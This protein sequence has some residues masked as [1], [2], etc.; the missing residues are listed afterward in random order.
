MIRILATLATLLALAAG[1]QTVAPVA[2]DPGLPEGASTQFINVG[3]LDRSYLL[4]VPADLPAAAPLVVVL[5]GFGG[6]PEV[7]E[8]RLGWNQ[9]A[10]SAKFI[11]AYP[12]GIG[13]SWNAGPACCGTASNRQIDD[14]GFITRVVSD[15]G[16]RVPIAQDRVYA[17][18]MSNGGMMA[19]TLACNSDV[20]AA[21]GAVSATQIGQCNPPRPTSLIQ[22]HGTNDPLVPYSGG[23][24]LGFGGGMPVPDVDAFWRRIDGCGAPMVNT[25]GELT[26]S[27]AVCEGGRGVELATVAGGN[28]SWPP[29]ATSM[30]WEFFV[31]H[32]R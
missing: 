13:V 11:V 28:H 31:A 17:V 21:I 12:V 25:D 5:H 16:T 6:G 30:I 19:L 29:F 20:F 24:G 15:I 22:I 27:T 18:G 1:L 7:S 26:T 4:Y 10:D 23:P 8:S 3:G 9:V 32:P 2:A 14:V